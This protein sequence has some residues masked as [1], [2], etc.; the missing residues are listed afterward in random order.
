MN[1]K[2]IKEDFK[3]LKQVLKQ[4]DLSHFKKITLINLSSKIGCYLILL[5]AAFNVFKG[6][7]MDVSIYIAL[8]GLFVRIVGLSYT[9]GQ[10]QKFKTKYQLT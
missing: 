10:L 8:A 7:I 6:G 4:E 3:K 1:A 2:Q 5:L 9:A